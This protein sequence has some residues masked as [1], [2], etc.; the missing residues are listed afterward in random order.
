[1]NL[2]MKFGGV[3]LF[4]AL[5]VL[6]FGGGNKN[7][8][9]PA[10][11]VQPTPQQ[12]VPTVQSAPEPPASA[13]QPP[14]Q[15]PPAQRSETPKEEKARGLANWLYICG[16]AVICVLAIIVIFALNPIK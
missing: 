11:A 15:Q 3:V 7:S 2:I 4:I 6:F 14:A 8:P 10:P 9:K 12:A 1:M 5:F 16:A 13:V